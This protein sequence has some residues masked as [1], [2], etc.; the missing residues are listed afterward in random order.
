MNKTASCVGLRQRNKF[1]PFI[2]FH[3][4]R[5]G[6]SRFVKKEVCCTET[7]VL[8]AVREFIPDLRFSFSI[9]NVMLFKKPEQLIRRVWSD[10]KVAVVL[11]DKNIGSPEMESYVSPFV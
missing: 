4:Y 2:Y 6:K 10:Y 11:V 3:D 7:V 9:G 8:C 1:F 5:I